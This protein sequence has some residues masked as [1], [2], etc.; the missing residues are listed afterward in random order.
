MI[1]LVLSSA[2]LLLPGD[3]DLFSKTTLCLD[4]G[5]LGVLAVYPV[6]VFLCGSIPVFN[7][8][9]ITCDVK[10]GEYTFS[11]KWFY[12]LVI[13]PSHTLHRFY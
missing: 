7:P 10:M 9:K 11:K 4:L 8:Q 12:E 5:V 2:K 6:F 1:D 13:N 3:S